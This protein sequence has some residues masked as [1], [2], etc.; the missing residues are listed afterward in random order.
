MCE[1]NQG[2]RGPSN[3][4]VEVACG[5]N[6]QFGE[7]PTVVAERCTES[8]SPGKKINNFFIKVSVK[9]NNCSF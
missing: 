1:S 3:T 5:A 2:V 6:E 7:F 8:L 9:I 4:H